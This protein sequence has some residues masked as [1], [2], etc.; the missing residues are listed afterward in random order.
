MCEE[1]MHLREEARDLIYILTIR[2]ASSPAFSRSF[3]ST[4]LST[5]PF[6]N[7]IK[8]DPEATGRTIIVTNEKKPNLAGLPR[9]LCTAYLHA[10]LFSQIQDIAEERE[11]IYSS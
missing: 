7:S 5:P 6:V 4:S 9:V 11:A 8:K 1:K 10:E 2:F 3:K